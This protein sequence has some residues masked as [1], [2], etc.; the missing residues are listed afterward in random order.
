MN[1]L[2]LIILL[3]ILAII[4]LPLL[5]IWSINTLAAAGGASFYIE[6]TVINWS[7]AFVLCLALRGGK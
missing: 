1:K 7:A 6:Q 2:I 5:L 3:V 4:T